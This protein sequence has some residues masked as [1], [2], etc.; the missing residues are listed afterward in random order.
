M[1]LFCLLAA[2]VCPACGGPG[3]VGT[4]LEATASPG[5][6]A[7]GA[8]AS[9]QVHLEGVDAKVPKGPVSG[10]GAQAPSLSVASA[11]ADWDFKARKVVFDGDVR[12]SR[13]D[14]VMS[15]DHLEV[16]YQ[17]ADRLEHATATGHVHIQRGDLEASSESAILDVD[18][19][20][21][22]LGG[23]P[24]IH[25]GAQRLAGDRILLWLDDERLE[26]EGCNLVVQGE[27]VRPLAP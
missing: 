2:L 14:F 10:D 20:R 6:Q 17:R 15:C 13:A 7:T 21:V 3:A 22:E 8:A 18:S 11:R 23:Q 12:A 27:A 5:A 4:V 16:S 24:R 25:Q 9:S 26:C 19:G 1:R